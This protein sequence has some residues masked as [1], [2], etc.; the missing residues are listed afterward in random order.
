MAAVKAVAEDYS[1][2]SRSAIPK[3]GEFEKKHREMIMRFDRERYEDKAQEIPQCNACNNRGQ[4]RVVMAWSAKRERFAPV[5]RG[6]VVYCEGKAYTTF[7]PC[8]CIRGM[9]LNA[10]P[11]YMY[12]RD[13]LDKIH[14]LYAY[15]NPIR[16]D[17]Y[18]LACINKPDQAKTED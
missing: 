18:A 17:D 5:E 12:R 14:E 9:K 11:I 10:N 16:A 4:M 8:S 7:A 13:Q 6:K 3:K 2:S 1:R 15:A